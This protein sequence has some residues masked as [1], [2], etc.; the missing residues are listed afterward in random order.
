MPNALKQLSSINFKW[1]TFFCNAKARSPCRSKHIAYVKYNFVVHEGEGV[2]HTWGNSL[3]RISWPYTLP[4]NNLLSATL[5]FSS[6]PSPIT[7]SSLLSPI[8]LSSLITLPFSFLPSHHPL[9]SL[10]PPPPHHLLLPPI[11]PSTSL[12]HLPPLILLPNPLLSLTPPPSP[13][14]PSYPP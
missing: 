7:S 10:T 8:N 2:Y 13:S 4:F 12:L 5:H 14:P 6:Y 1:Q 9:L 3:L 11:L